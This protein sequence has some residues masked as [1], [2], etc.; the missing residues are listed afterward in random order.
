M[1]PNY[2]IY[3][4]YLKTGQGEAVGGFHWPP[5]LWTSQCS[6][7]NIFHCYMRNINILASLFGWAGW[8]GY[9]LIA[10]PED[11]KADGRSDRQAASAGQSRAVTRECRP[12]YQQVVDLNPTH[13]VQARH[14][15]FIAYYRFKLENIPT[16]WP[17]WVSY[18]YCSSGSFE[19]TMVSLWHMAKESSG[20]LSEK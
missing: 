17:V 10:N 6:G 13:H 12:R 8:F 16:N 20:A 18:S 9:Y 4:G 15:T 19:C 1:R 2:F 3:I 5:P 7:K 11:M 14:S